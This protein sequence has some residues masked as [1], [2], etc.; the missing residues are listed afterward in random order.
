MAIEHPSDRVPPPPPVTSGAL[1]RRALAQLH[2]ASNRMW[3]EYWMLRCTARA[4]SEDFAIAGALEESFALHLRNLHCFLYGG[5]GRPDGIGAEDFFGDRWL[6]MRPELSP[7]LAE[8]L[9]WAEQRLAPPSYSQASA[10]NAPRC[11]RL[12]QA[13]FELQ[14]AMDTFISNLPRD[15]L[16]SRWKIIYDEGLAV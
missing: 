3:H 11:W 10:V 13:S 8:V 9:A 15:L 14:K 16:G 7:L 4:A 2:A 6:A 5:G 12:V 1:P